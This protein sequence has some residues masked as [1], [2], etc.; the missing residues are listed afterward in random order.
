MRPGC[1]L[2]ANRRWQMDEADELIHQPYIGMRDSLLRE[3]QPETGQPEVVAD[4]RTRIGIPFLLL[5]SPC[6]TYYMS[7]TISV[8]TVVVV[9]A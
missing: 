7:Q 6:C 8:K 4:P 2:K 9:S 5:V 3:G 1:K